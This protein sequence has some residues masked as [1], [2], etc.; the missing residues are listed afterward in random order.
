ML[1]VSDDLA[2][3]IIIYPFHEHNHSHSPDSSTPLV[4][5]QD[6]GRP[7]RGLVPHRAFSEVI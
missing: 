5:C 7:A 2:H 3:F 4:L 6:A 1:L